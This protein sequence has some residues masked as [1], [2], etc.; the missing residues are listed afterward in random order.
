MTR[1]IFLTAYVYGSLKLSQE[2]EIIEWPGLEAALQIN[3][4]ATPLPWA[5]IPSTRPRC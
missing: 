3:L 5:R 4:F 2:E 1:L